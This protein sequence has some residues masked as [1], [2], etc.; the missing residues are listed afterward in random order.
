[1]IK[2]KSVHEPID[3]KGDGLRILASRLRGRSMKKTQYDVW[4]ANLGPSQKL[5]EAFKGGR[6]PWDEFM[7]RYQAEMF[8][9]PPLDQG[10]N[11]IKNHGQK[12]TL[13]LLKE[14]GKRGTVTVMCQC[15]KDEQHCHRHTLKKLIER[16]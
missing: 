14:L 8:E 9:N 3:R 1:M 10:N 11:L 12:F 16:A 2:T 13:R 4:M 6:L 7:Q 5:L 15:A